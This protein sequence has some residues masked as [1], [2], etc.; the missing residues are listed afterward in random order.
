MSGSHWASIIIALFLGVPLGVTALAIFR[1][2]SFVLR[3]VALGMWAMLLLQVA[4]LALA[5]I[6]GPNAGRWP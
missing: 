1:R 5:G 6:Y 4:Y 2:Q 3:G